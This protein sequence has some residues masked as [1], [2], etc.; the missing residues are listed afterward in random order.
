MAKVM[1]VEEVRERLRSRRDPCHPDCRGWDVFATGRGLEVER[2]D[3]CFH[4]EEDPL[5]DD[6]VEL[7]P[8][9][10]EALR[11]ARLGEGVELLL[12]V[13][14]GDAGPAVAAALEA[15]VPGAA[16]QVVRAD[17]FALRI[18]RNGEPVVDEGLAAHARELAARFEAE[19]VEGRCRR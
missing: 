1:T 7:L 19:L 13:E 8:E 17:A 14:A 12:V 4:G 16:S 15:A 5:G 9:A 18:T 10:Q 2:C 3:D 11:I 6:D